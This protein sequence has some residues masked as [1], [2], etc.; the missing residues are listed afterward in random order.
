MIIA[1]QGEVAEKRLNSMGVSKKSFSSVYDLR[2]QFFG[3]PSRIDDFPC[4]LT[5]FCS[6]LGGMVVLRE[7]SLRQAS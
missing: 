7:F 4:N 2:K 5:Q 6:R 3:H 1:K